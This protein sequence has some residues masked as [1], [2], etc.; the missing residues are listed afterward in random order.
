M[1]C[2]VSNLSLGV[3]D[4]SELAKDQTQSSGVHPQQL[5]FLRFGGDSL[6]GRVFGLFNA[7]APHSDS[8]EGRGGPWAPPPFSV[9]PQKLCRSSLDFGLAR[10]F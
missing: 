9:N 4:L 2:L 1:S 5:W 8:L 3:I 7:K 10:I 6:G